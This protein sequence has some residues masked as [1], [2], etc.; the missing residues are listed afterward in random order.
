MSPAFVPNCSQNLRVYKGMASPKLQGNQANQQTHKL[1]S[2]NHTSK[3]GEKM[4]AANKTNAARGMKGKVAMAYSK[5]IKGQNNAA[6]S[7][8]QPYRY[9]A[10]SSSSVEAATTAA[11]TYAAPDNIDERA[12]AFILAVRERIR[13]EHKML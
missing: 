10:T 6:V 2:N 5:Y 4:E 11:A 8:T 7:I 1:R 3:P 9:Q 13:N 12:T